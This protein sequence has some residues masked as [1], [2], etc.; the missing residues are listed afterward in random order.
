MKKTI[1]FIASALL[2]VVTILCSNK[3]T[4]ADSKST[5]P[6]KE[7][8]ILFIGNSFT[9]A[10]FGKQAQPM[11]GVPEL[12]ARIAQ[13]GGNAPE[14]KMIAYPSM[15]LRQHFENGHNELPT[16]RS[17]KW[18]YVVLQG[19]SLE[20]TDAARRPGDFVEF[21]KKFA[22]VIRQNNPATKVVLYETWAY[23]KGHPKYADNFGEQS[24]MLEQISAG[25][26]SL[27]REIDGAIVA[28]VGDAFYEAENGAHHYDLY[29]AKDNHH[30]N[31]TGY[32]LSALVLV[33]SIYGELPAK[34]TP[35]L[36]DVSSNDMQ[37]L[38]SIANAK[39][40]AG[41]Q[42]KAR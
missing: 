4:N 26:K 38:A 11:G 19:Q 36:T 12:F 17:R 3:P 37:Q 18:D 27:A 31:D 21:G 28:P 29:A 15:T 42:T 10:D 2:L 22:E 33:R 1:L 6:P 5:P 16:I 14:V 34:I 35:V 7:V 32:T 9:F 30:A 13:Q 41:E 24:K 8:S 40:Q 39:V 20:A 23:P 25:Y